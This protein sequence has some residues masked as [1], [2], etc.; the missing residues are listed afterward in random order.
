MT[1]AGTLHDVCPLPRELW[2]AGARRGFRIRFRSRDG[3]T[4]GSVFFPEASGHAAESPL[5][6]W[7]HCF[8]GLDRHNMPSRRGL[9]GAELKHLSAWLRRGFAV[10]APDYEGLDGCGISPFPA[11]DGIAHDVVTICLAAQELDDSVGSAVVAGG[12]CQGAAAVLHATVPPHLRARL[13][14][15]A[16]VALSP[17]DYAAYFQHVTR[18]PD[19]PADAL[20]LTLLA[21]TRSADPRLCP[22]EFLTCEGKEM[23]DAATSHSVPELRTLLA[24]YTVADLGIQDIARHPALAE[25]F[26]RSAD[27]PPAAANRVLLASVA[28]DPTVP[29]DHLRRITERVA[30]HGCEVAQAS[31]AGRHMDVLSLAAS[32]AV[33]WAAECTG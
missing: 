23:L 25:A 8:L 1:A 29:P 18:D 31:Y 10:A 13:D 32:D 21:G 12:F 11:P 15:R 22:E 6:T 24:P 9:P 27:V 33:R 2:P 30:A 4:S 7:A 28:G 16:T 14:H 20:V 5:L 3:V 19:F 26:E 17:P